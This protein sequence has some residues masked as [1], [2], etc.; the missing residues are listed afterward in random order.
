MFEAVGGFVV[1]TISF[2]STPPLQRVL[3]NLRYRKLLSGKKWSTQVHF[4]HEAY[5][6]GGHHSLSRTVAV[7]FGVS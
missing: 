4:N 3:V 6:K 7:M 1:S 2:L 5:M